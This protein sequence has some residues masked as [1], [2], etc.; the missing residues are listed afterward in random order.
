[1]LLALYKSSAKENAD[2]YQHQ[3]SIDLPNAL[4]PLT[5]QFSLSIQIKWMRTEN[6]IFGTTNAFNRFAGIFKI[7]LS[8]SF[9]VLKLFHLRLQRSL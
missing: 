2:K 6:Q 1:M 7:I 5:K 8:C 4:Q 9:T 3:W